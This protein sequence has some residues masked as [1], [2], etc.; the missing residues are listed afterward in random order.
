[1]FIWDVSIVFT[2]FKTLPEP[3]VLSLKLLTHKLVL[4]M[5][6]I[7]GGQR[8][9]TLHSIDIADMTVLSDSVAFAITTKLKQTKPSKH[10]AP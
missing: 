2:Y 9:Q 10:F 3:S 4:L 6:L 7:S 5:S 8:S 1:M